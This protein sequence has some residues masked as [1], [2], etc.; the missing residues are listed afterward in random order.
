MSMG[1]RT[2][3]KLALDGQGVVYGRCRSAFGAFLLARG[4]IDQ[5]IEGVLS[6]WLEA[7]EKTTRMRYRTT[8]DGPA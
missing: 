2:S 3:P 1:E 4:K 6:F 7:C 8:S 5:S